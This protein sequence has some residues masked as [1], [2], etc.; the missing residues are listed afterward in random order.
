MGRTARALGVA[1]AIALIGASP[2][3]GADVPASV[4]PGKGARGREAAKGATYR[5]G[6]MT[7]LGS[8][9]QPGILFF[10]PRAEVRLLPLRSD[11]GR[12]AGLLADDKSSADIPE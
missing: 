9:E 12:E 7:I 5:P 2:T 4:T 1:C 6:P 3:G 8:P 10:L 11:P